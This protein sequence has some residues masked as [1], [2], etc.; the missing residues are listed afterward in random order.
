M[1]NES[2]EEIEEMKL[3]RVT[4]MM[5]GA[6]GGWCLNSGGFYSRPFSCS[7]YNWPVIVFVSY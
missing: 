5:Q 1:E 4:L 3:T 2:E 7:V 6:A